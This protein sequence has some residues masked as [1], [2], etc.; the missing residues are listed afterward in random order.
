MCGVDTLRML[1]SRRSTLARFALPLAMLSLLLVACVPPPGG[2][3]AFARDGAA[4]IEFEAHRGGMGQLYIYEVMSIPGDHS[5]V[6]YDDHATLV[7][8]LENGTEYRFKMR[9]RRSSDPDGTWG[10][11]SEPSAPVVPRGRPAAPA[12]SQVAG[13]VDLETGCTARV[14]FTPGSDNGAPITGY[15]VSVTG[16]SA[17]VRGTRSPIEVSGLTPHT[18]YTFTVRAINAAGASPA[19]AAFTGSCS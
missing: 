1:T 18:P 5:K 9:S 14:T 8:G 3:S 7:T 11:W 10:P 16:G 6:V 19:S 15:E 13:F 4:K 17:P 12:I 2:I